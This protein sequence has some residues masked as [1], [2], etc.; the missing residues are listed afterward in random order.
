MKLNNLINH[1][2]YTISVRKSAAGAGVSA[3]VWATSSD[4]PVV[5]TS[6]SFS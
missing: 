6:A 3:A 4:G 2:K 1:N 5:A